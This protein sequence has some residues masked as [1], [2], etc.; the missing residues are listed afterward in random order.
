MFLNTICTN[1]QEGR[2]PAATRGTHESMTDISISA[3]SSFAWYNTAQQ[4]QML[5][6]KKGYGRC[7]EF[8]DASSPRTMS[9]TNAAQNC[10]M[11]PQQEYIL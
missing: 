1:V 3:Q 5:R 11:L 7:P 6:K 8:L 2:A 10:N 9:D 4:K